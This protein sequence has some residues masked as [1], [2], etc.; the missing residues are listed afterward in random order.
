LVL[1]RLYAQSFVPTESV[2]APGSESAGAWGLLTIK[3]T[4]KSRSGARRPPC[5]KV[6]S[7]RLGPF[8]RSQTCVAYSP[9][10]RCLARRRVSAVGNTRQR[11][12]LRHRGPRTLARAPS[13]WPRIAEQ[14]TLAYGARDGAFPRPLPL[15]KEQDRPRD[16]QI[17]AR[18]IL[19]RVPLRW[20]THPVHT[21]QVPIDARAR[22]LMR[23]GHVQL[24]H[25]HVEQIS[26]S[27]SEHRPI[28]RTIR[29]SNS[30][31]EPLW[32]RASFWSRARLRSATTTSP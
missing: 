21:A 27:C 1:I 14:Q 17:R 4:C 3:H 31:K 24:A 10:S 15:P 19:M 25:G 13:N 18:A 22:V 29:P 11:A 2:R 9:A 16:A 20:S 30:L 7:I 8:A 23:F 12:D 5:A 6:L 32:S 26:D 28:R